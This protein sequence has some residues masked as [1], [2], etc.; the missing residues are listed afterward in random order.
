[1]TL[2]SVAAIAATG[3]DL[4]SVGAL[5]HSASALDISLDLDLLETT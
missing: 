3:V 5:T 4:I 2:E 1:V